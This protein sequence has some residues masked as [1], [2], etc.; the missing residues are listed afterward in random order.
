MD[1][2]RT[3]PAHGVDLVRVIYQA[4]PSRELPVILGGTSRGAISAVA[5][6]DIADALALSSPVTAGSGAGVYPVGSGK[7]SPANVEGPS[8]VLW[9]VND[10]CSKSS[11]SG[12][13][14]L[15]QNLT[16]AATSVSGG[17]VHTD[18]LKAGD[19]GAFSYH[20]FLGIESCAVQQQ[21]GW[22][23]SLSLANP[24]GTLQMYVLD[25]IGGAV[26]NLDMSVWLNA[27]DV[28][29]VPHGTSSLGGSVAVNGNV[30]IYTPPPGL[31][32]TRDSFAYVVRM[33][34]GAVRQG[35]LYMNLM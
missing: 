8:H 17:F 24:T 13:W 18:P 20:G 10:A 30:V 4:D 7:A 9:H 21:T 28:L 23:D 12:A 32:G 5:Q 22:M 16:A 3:S 35:V 26:V 14:N 2:Y 19:C 27:G 25:S 11:P 31:T 29:L 33:A 34:S 15:A 1:V 6:T